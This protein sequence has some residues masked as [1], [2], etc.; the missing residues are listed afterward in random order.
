[1]LILHSSISKMS[2]SRTPYQPKRSGVKLYL[3]NVRLPIPL[4]SAVE[5]LYSDEQRDHNAHWA[6]KLVR[7][8]Y[9]EK[10]FQAEQELDKYIPVPYEYISAILKNPERVKNVWVK[11]LK[12]GIFDQ[13]KDLSYLFLGTLEDNLEESEVKQNAGGWKTDSCYAFKFKPE[14]VT[15]C[16]YEWVYYEDTEKEQ[17]QILNSLE[18]KTK[19][20]IKKVKLNNTSPENIEEVLEPERV[21]LYEK[22]TSEL[23]SDELDYF[24][25]KD[26]KRVK[27]DIEYFGGVEQ[28]IQSR[29]HSTLN[30]YVTRLHQFTHHPTTEIP[31]PKLSKVNGRLNHLLTYTPKFIIPHLIINGEKL[32]E[33]DLRNSQ[34]CLLAN[35]LRSPAILIQSGK[36]VLMHLYDYITSQA[37]TRFIM[38]PEAPIQRNKFR[39]KG[40]GEMTYGSVYYM[41]SYTLDIEN[42]ITASFSGTLYNDLGK[43][44]WVD[45]YDENLHRDQIKEEC[46]SIFYG[47]YIPEKI[48]TSGSQGDLRQHFWTHYP[49]LMSLINN[50]KKYMVEI[51]EST[52]DRKLLALTKTRKSYDSSI[53][54]YR[55]KTPTE[56]GS[57]YFS[58]AM[59]ILESSIFVEGILAEL[60][61]E[62][63]SVLSKHDSFLIPEGSFTDVMKC[64]TS[65]LERLLGK[66]RFTLGVT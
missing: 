56:A 6:L 51:Y 42:F 65:Q 17:K 47:P 48:Q 53:R 11:K 23:E 46:F 12:E 34:F 61:Y 39:R 38:E 30:I 8:I 59:Q 64:I 24:K 62:G 20:L 27:V 14:L 22:Y 1:M 32:V 63:F 3:K 7:R 16:D 18:R 66:G 31:D 21:R 41:L 10:Y 33:V 36:P 55:E 44:I 26:G 37:C 19:S 43:T 40:D 60:N 9:F 54:D 50:F 57:D 58:I 2:F 5:Q 15:N 45:R 35:V 13:L 49:N 28:Y 29:V 52:N 4:I 25:I